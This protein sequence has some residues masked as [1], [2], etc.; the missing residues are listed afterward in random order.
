MLS[1]IIIVLLVAAIFILGFIIYHF[2]KLAKGLLLFN[3]QLKKD[4]QII[5]SESNKYA[6]DYYNEVA[7]KKRLYNIFKTIKQLYYLEQEDNRLIRKANEQ[8]YGDRYQ[9]GFIM[10]Y[11]HHEERISNKDLSNLCLSKN[12]FVR[13]IDGN[14]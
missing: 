5:Q 9:A 6:I 2:H 8:I 4:L 10:G 13:S 12:G 3:T 11:K 7:K 14:S 1:S